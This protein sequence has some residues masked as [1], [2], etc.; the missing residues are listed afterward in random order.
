MTP[1]GINRH[2]EQCVEMIVKHWKPTPTEAQLRE[3]KRGLRV[4]A[5]RL[6]REVVREAKRK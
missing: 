3:I 5:D 2:M 1:K 4:R 6:R